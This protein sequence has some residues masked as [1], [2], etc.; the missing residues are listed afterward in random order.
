MGRFVSFGEIMLRLSAPGQQRFTQASSLEMNF[1][2]GEANVAVALA[3]FG[4]AAAFVTRLPGN[5]LGEACVRDL[6]G[7]GVDTSEIVRG[8]ERLGLY[9]LENGASQRPAQV[10]YDRA[11]SAF[12]KLDPAE[13]DW[14]RILDGAEWFHFSG[15]TPA[16]SESAA[17]AVATGAALARRKGI[18]VSCDVNYRAKLWG[19]VE[20][21]RVMTALM[22]HVDYC[23]ANEGHTDSILGIV[24]PGPEKTT[25][26]DRYLD[27]AEKLVA[28]FGFKGVVLTLRETHSALR[29]TFGG[30]YCTG[31]QVF[32]SRSYNLEIVDRIG[33]GDA[34]AAG[35]VHGLMEKRDPQYVV[36]F[37]TAA[38]C[39]KHSVPG[40]YHVGT[41]AEIET[42]MSGDGSPRVQR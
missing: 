15:I 14:E 24:P 31:G 36:E 40:D 25:D 21:K 22:A 29:N 17:Q 13:F 19:M 20:A 28:K 5:D 11:G 34:F 37:A 30:V 16:V 33:G 2:G 38:G 39:L 42:L 1:G 7:V 41:R 8:G 23:I 10:I 9:F 6:R 12:A 35:F 27:I 32:R 18:P 3:Q 4:H 26:L